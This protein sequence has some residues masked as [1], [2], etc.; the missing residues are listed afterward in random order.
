MGKF[1][2]KIR[3]LLGIKT[4]HVIDMTHIYQTG[5]I[6]H[7]PKNFIIKFPSLS[8][9]IKCIPYGDISEDLLYE[10]FENSLREINRRK[11]KE[12][13]NKYGD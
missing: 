12:N 9:R 6:Q 1:I 5:K 8:D 4:V 3:D 7:L 13:G 10:I 2:Q 11:S